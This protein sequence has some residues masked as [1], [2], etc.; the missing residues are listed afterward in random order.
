MKNYLLTFFALVLVS[1]AIRAQEEQLPNTLLW[2][3]EGPDIESSFLFGTIHLMPQS[4]FQLK[5]KVTA[6]F[7]ECTK[8]VM[9]LDIDD[10]NMQAEISRNAAMKNG[11]EMSDLISKEQMQALDQ[12]LRESIGTGIENFKT[13]KP[14][15]LSSFLVPRMLGDNPVSYEL[16]FKQRAVASGVEIE[17]LETVADQMAVFDDIP[18]SEQVQDL[19]EMI[20]EEDKTK[21]EYKKMLELYQ[22]ENIEELY[23]L[24]VDYMDNDD[25]LNTLILNRNKAWL[26][27]IQGFASQESTFFA[28]GAGHLAGEYGVVKILRNAGYQ[29]TPVGVVNQD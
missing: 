17:G 8:V 28:V 1:T 12:A 2:K 18:Y 15:L 5:S 24:L 9:E 10:P 25:E 29:L 22:G 19:L 23:Q 14:F 11:K 27:K 6:A 16:Q 4:E 3:L 20:E 21:Q 26:P 7:Q 13:F